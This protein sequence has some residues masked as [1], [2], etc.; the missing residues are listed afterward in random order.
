MQLN[1]NTCTWMLSLELH[2]DCYKPILSKEVIWIVMTKQMYIPSVCF[3]TNSK[4]L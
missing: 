2:M 1:D 4:I 3:D